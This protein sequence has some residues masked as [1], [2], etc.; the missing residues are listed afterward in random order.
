MNRR[1][2]EAQRRE[3][4][5][6]KQEGSINRGKEVF[7]VIFIKPCSAMIFCLLATTAPAVEPSPSLAEEIARH[8]VSESNNTFMHAMERDKDKNRRL[9]TLWRSG[10]VGAMVELW[11]ALAKAK[12]MDMQRGEPKAPYIFAVLNTGTTWVA[13]PVE[14][15]WVDPNGVAYFMADDKEEPR[16]FFRY[17]APELWK[18]A[19]KHMQN[20][21]DLPRN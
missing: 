18:W 7:T 6:E 19:W 10:D 15:F 21:R 8:G 13:R 12:Y 14:E 20:G 3:R 9:F 16:L 5:R 17:K 1:D 4:Q 2:A 11:K